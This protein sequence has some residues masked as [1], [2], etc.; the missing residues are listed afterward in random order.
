MTSQYSIARVSTPIF[1]ALVASALLITSAL[2]APLS[3]DA[4]LYF[5]GLLNQRTWFAPH[6]RWINVPLQAPTLMVSHLTANLRILALI[7]SLCYASVPMI[8][9]GVSYLICRHRRE[10]FIWP[11]LAIGL[12]TLP[13]IFAFNAEAIMIASLFWPIGLAAL[14]GVSSGVEFALVALLA[15]A[16]LISH[17]TAGAYFAMAA[18]IGYV[19]AKRSAAK[20]VSY[21]GPLALGLLALVRLF[22]PINDYER[23][24]LAMATLRDNFTLALNGWPLA[25]VVLTF[26]AAILCLVEGTRRNSNLTADLALL[27]TIILAGLMLVPWSSNPHLWWRE[28]K[29][30]TWMIPIHGALMV[31][32]ALDAWREADRGFL[33]RQRQPALIAIGAVFLI[34][35]SIQSA[36]WNQLTHRL[37]DAMRGGGCIPAESLTWIEHTP[38]DHWSLSAYAIDLQGRTPRSLVLDSIYCDQFAAN[39]KVRLSFFSIENGH[40]FDF[41][42]IRDGAVN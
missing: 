17:P 14:I 1:F 23:G 25:V 13:G 22:M 42:H 8:G 10:L 19:S 29:Y 15:I 11:A 18:S 27:A 4:G 9:L 34:V 33:W 7:F 28:S 32:C 20:L 6:Q 30:R 39:G 16:A 36:R 2:R 12:G 41:T 21:L 40:W 31:A 38:F 35:L 5:F 26:V 37:Q 24:Q 3:W